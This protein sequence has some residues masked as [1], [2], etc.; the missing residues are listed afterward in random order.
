MMRGLYLV[1][2]FQCNL[3]KSLLFIATPGIIN[4]PP[5]VRLT[6]SGLAA[7]AALPGIADILGNSPIFK[8][9]HLYILPVAQYTMRK[10]LL[11]N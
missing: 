7:L 4:T 1:K 8:I 2:N 6:G 9:E 3:N 11:Y 5:P 10:L